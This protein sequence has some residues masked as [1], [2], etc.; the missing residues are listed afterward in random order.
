M[1]VRY[2]LG[3]LILLSIASLRATLLSLSILTIFLIATSISLR[4]SIKNTVKNMRYIFI[5][6]LLVFFARALST[7][8]TPLIALNDIAIT[9]QGIYLGALVCWRILTVIFISLL[10]IA[11][12]KANQIKAAVQWFFKPVPMIPEKRVAIMISLTLRCIPLILDQAKKTSDA[13]QARGIGN[14]KNPIYR[15][16][17]FSVPVIRRSF[18]TADKLAIAMEARAYSEN[19]TDPTFSATPKDISIF[20]SIL[21]LTIIFYLF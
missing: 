5:F 3:C 15:I 19:R 1:D 9:T 20:C 13:Q 11:T 6:L 10:F 8:G 16:I 7:P 4:L 14:R 2:K 12:T 18:E 17:R 21:S